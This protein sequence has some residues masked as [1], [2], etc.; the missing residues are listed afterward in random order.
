MCSVKLSVSDLIIPG[1][2]LNPMVEKIS[3][4]EIRKVS[5]V[6]HIIK[7]KWGFSRSM[8]AGV[9]CYPV[10]IKHLTEHIVQC[11][12]IFKSPDSKEAG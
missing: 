8:H 5:S 12:N 2:K 4:S 7:L 6:I 9:H 10:I 3:I 1:L 11:W